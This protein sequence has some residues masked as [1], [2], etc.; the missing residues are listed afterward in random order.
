MFQ[1]KAPDD[2]SAWLPPGD[3]SRLAL[4]YRGP[5]SLPG[6]PEAVADLL[7][8]GPWGFAVRFVGPREVR[9]VSPAALAGA[10]LYAQPGGGELRPAWRRL[11]RHAETVRAFVRGG[12]RYL[13]FC[14]GTYLA[15]A[16]P[17]FGLVPGDVARYPVVSGV[18]RRTGAPAVVPVVWRGR[19]RSMYVQD[20]PYVALDARLGQA[21]VLAVYA[22]GLPAAV[23]APFGRGLVGVVGPHPEATPDWFLADGLRPPEPLALDLGVDLVDEVMSG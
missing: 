12:G 19:V 21:R 9:D 15:G 20:P 10:A 17:G 6:C 7:Q 3:D 18:G 22:D 4:V 23:V 2:G 8:R 16:S 14:L 11:Q 5:A 13:G 1:R